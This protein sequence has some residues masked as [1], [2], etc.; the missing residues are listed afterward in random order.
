MT[1]EMKLPALGEN[2]ENAEVI[3]VLVSEG[4]VLTLDQPVIELETDKATAEV[5]APF[6][7]TVR[8]IHVAKGDQVKVGQ[9]ILTVDEA[10]E[11]AQPTT[12]A[13]SDQPE[14][15]EVLAAPA[16]AGSDV[17]P[18]KELVED[19]LPA[20]SK[21]AAQSAP[22]LAAST[23]PSP[24]A[25]PPPPVAATA[26]M[27]TGA[28][29]AASP[30]VRRL[31]RELGITVSAVRGTGKDGRI[32]VEDVKNHARSSLADT[33]ADS[34]AVSAVPGGGSLPDFSR[35]GEIDRQPLS[36]VRRN[37]A[38]N[39]SFAWRT[40]PHVSQFDRADV[41]ALQ[42]F[43]QRYSRKVE[44]A[45][46][47]LTM[48]AIV[49]KLTAAALRTFPRFNSSFDEERQELILK[50]YINMG[51][52]VD[53]ERGLLVPVIRDADRKSLVEIGVELS[54]LAERT[55]QRK[56]SLDDLQGGSFTISNLG[57]L[58][59]TYFTPIINWPE[60]A[61]LGVGRSRREAVEIDGELVARTILPL[62]VSYDHRVIDGADAARFLRW[63]AEAMENPLLMA[64]EN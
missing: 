45:G 14:A 24:P 38:A 9:V 6:A 18:Q 34:P 19:D 36:R 58:G 33:P 60:V 44:S 48:T 22:A 11:V 53:T 8:K 5:P 7:G 62:S 52:A 12:A 29:V 30:S 41:T 64:L 20:A 31:A 39:L 15:A 3:A 1:R 2:I 61:I 59:T 16:S 25:A 37:I 27:A 46:G 43:R 50:N 26:P 57:G 49:V 17:V 63:L 4:D 54:T 10:A 35:W 42:T 23:A 56:A 55:R 28:P 40:I 21:P 32:R 47:K 51:V 13:P